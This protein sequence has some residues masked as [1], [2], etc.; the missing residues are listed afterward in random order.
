M[1]LWKSDIKYG[2]YLIK[3]GMHVLDQV[4]HV[5]D[6]NINSYKQLKIVMQLMSHGSEVD[7]DNE[8]ELKNGKCYR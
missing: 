3:Y 6:V 1:F 4:R 8:Q 2:M 5:L 7:T